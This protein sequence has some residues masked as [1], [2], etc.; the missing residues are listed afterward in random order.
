M[1]VSRTSSKKAPSQ[2]PVDFFNCKQ[3]GGSGVG[4]STAAVSGK[5]GDKLKSGPLR[6]KIYGRSNLGK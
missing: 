5:V 6:E 1:A 2:S 4:G 3:A